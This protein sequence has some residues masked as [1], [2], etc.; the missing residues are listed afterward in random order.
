MILKQ[1]PI[2]H[3]HQR[4]PNPGRI[5]RCRWARS[6]WRQPRRLRTPRPGRTEQR[7]VSVLWIIFTVRECVSS[8]TKKCISYILI[9]WD[10]VSRSWRWLNRIDVIKSDINQTRSLVKEK[11]KPCWWKQHTVVQSKYINVDQWKDRTKPGLTLEN[12]SHQS[13]TS[14]EGFSRPCPG[15]SQFVV[16]SY[17]TVPLWWLFF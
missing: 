4:N 2:T 7:T 6:G 1:G 3:P 8:E 17:Q 16:G 12:K 5:R 15:P 13:W 9:G 14:S 10:T 11:K